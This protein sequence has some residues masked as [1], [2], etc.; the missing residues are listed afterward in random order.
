MKKLNI[1]KFFVLLIVI[2]SIFSYNNYSYAIG[3]EMDK[4][5]DFI[6]VGKGGETPIN[7]PLVNDISSVLYSTI[8]G[9]GMIIAFGIGAMLGI[10]Y[11]TEGAEGKAKVKETFIPYVLGV[12]VLFGSFTIWK[13]A[14]N[15][16]KNI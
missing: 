10:K 5:D 12:G 7:Q 16:T 4:S 1:K 8:T 9:I 11:M 6:N 13:I 15:L 14:I 3:A 2:I